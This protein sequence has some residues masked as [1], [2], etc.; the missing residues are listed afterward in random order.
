[1]KVKNLK[2]VIGLMITAVLFAVSAIVT[3]TLD[4]TPDWLPQVCDF[5]S[6]VCSLLGIK[7]VVPTKETD[8]PAETARTFPTTGSTQEKSGLDPPK[9]GKE[10]N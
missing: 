10:D 9:M 5:A 8:I 7:V 3:G 6:V 1:M 4:V 2:A